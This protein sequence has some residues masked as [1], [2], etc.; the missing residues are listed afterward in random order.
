[1]AGRYRSMCSL[2]DHL[3]KLFRLCGLNEQR[4]EVKM[5]PKLV[6][7]MENF[8]KDT[9][10]CDFLDNLDSQTEQAIKALNGRQLDLW[11]SQETERKLE[12]TD[13]MLQKAQQ[14]I[15]D[16]E[17]QIK[18]MA[19]RAVTLEQQLEST[20]WALDK[21]NEQLAQNDP[22]EMIRNIIAMGDNLLMR[23]DYLREN[24]PEDD[25]A[26]KLIKNQLR[27]TAN[28]LK[29]AG[30]EILEDEGIFDCS[31][32][33]VVDT[34]LTTDPSLDNQIAEVFRP[35]YIYKGSVIRG[36]EVILYVYQTEEE[37]V[38]H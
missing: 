11:N 24:M 4:V 15:E 26:D 27:E 25:N 17:Q 20:Q 22:E 34:R 21:A 10:L 14:R 32:H 18:E 19:E 7:I 9:T 31:R 35:G 2:R 30:V 36:Q 38:C 1:M 33:T 5:S 6:T 8:F 28:I 23:R 16:R 13:E 37:A 12:E 29:K 3:E